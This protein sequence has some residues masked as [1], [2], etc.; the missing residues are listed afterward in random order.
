MAGF[1][2]TSPA[3]EYAAVN[4]LINTARAAGMTFDTDIGADAIPTVVLQSM[5]LDGVPA[6]AGLVGSP[7]YSTTGDS[8]TG[9]WFSAANKVDVSA[10]GVRV[11][12]A[13]TAS[14]GVNFLDFTAAAASAN[15]QIAAAGADTN[16]SLAL[17]G[18]GTGGVTIGG[19]NPIGIA[20]ILQATLTPSAVAANTVVEQTFT[21]FTGLTTADFAIGVVKPTCQGGLLIG[22]TR[23]VTTNNLAIH[24]G[25]TTGSAITPTAGQV[26]TVFTVSLGVDD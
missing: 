26:Y 16:V 20:R 17:A 2:T 3:N 15:P 24:F 8:D 13:N 9:M 5:L 6:G 11:W 21:T 22:Q 19:G 1:G 25:N 14:S 12:R 10:G 4:S 23:V 18:K 7:A